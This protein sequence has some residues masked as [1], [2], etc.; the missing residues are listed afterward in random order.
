MAVECGITNR[1]VAEAICSSHFIREIGVSR[2]IQQIDE[3][4]FATEIW[5]HQG[6]RCAFNTDATLLLILETDCQ[7]TNNRDDRISS[8]TTLRVSV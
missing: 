6:H 4:G 8:E 1:A 7:S 2:A 3:V 5:Q